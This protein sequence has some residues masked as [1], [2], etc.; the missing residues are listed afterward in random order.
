MSF[1]SNHLTLFNQVNYTRDTNLDQ[2]PFGV[3]PIWYHK[4]NELAFFNSL[5]MKLSVIILGLIE[6]FSKDLF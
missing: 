2:Y 3:D 1:L 5:K 6:I 4:V